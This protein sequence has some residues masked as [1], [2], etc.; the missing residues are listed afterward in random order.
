MFDC[1]EESSNDT[2]KENYNADSYLRQNADSCRRAA[3]ILV[4][5][6]DIVI[7]SKKLLTIVC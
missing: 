6:P 2:R 7:F 3:E 1:L 4:E 5:Q